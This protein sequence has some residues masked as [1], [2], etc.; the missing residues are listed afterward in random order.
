MDPQP[1]LQ[2]PRG[3]D[4]GVQKTGVPEAVQGPWSRPSGRTQT[5]L[6]APSPG[7]HG[8]RPPCFSTQ[9]AHTLTCALGQQGV[10]PQCMGAHGFAADDALQP[11]G[12]FLSR[13]QRAWFL[14]SPE[15]TLLTA[16]SVHRSDLMGERWWPSPPPLT[17][18]VRGLRERVSG[19]LISFIPSLGA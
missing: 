15:A 4:C 3:V 1:S 6:A 2:S 17:A 18:F 11:P 10:H 13:S 12:S 16:C 14:E 7:S 19:S 9:A 5:H 8:C